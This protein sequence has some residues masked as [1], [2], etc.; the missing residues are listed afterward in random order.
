MSVLLIQETKRKVGFIK[1]SY[2]PSNIATYK[3]S[4]TY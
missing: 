3:N 2:I 4:Y 1:F